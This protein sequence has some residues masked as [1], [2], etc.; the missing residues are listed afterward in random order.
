MIPST[1][2]G[3]LRQLLSEHFL[4]SHSEEDDGVLTYE[5]GIGNDT[6]AHMD[7]GAL[8]FRCHQTIGVNLSVI[9]TAIPRYDSE[10]GRADYFDRIRYRLEVFEHAAAHFVDILEEDM[11]DVGKD[12]LSLVTDDNGRRLHS[13][14]MALFA[15]LGAGLSDATITLCIVICSGVFWARWH[16][17]AWL[18][19]AGAGALLFAFRAA[20]HA[21]IARRFAVAYLDA[22]Q[23]DL[24]G[25][26]RIPRMG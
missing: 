5:F 8:A 17:V 18:W 13:L 25:P 26:V 3:K 19:V 21:W 22:R 23:G 14:R 4:L 20:R 24:P 12:S 7:L 1:P 16:D 6:P 2:E 11:R 15:E 10:T 9:S